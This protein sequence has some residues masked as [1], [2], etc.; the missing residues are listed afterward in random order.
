MMRLQRAKK[1][2]KTTD[3]LGAVE[4]EQRKAFGAGG[5]RRS[6]GAAPRVSDFAD[7]PAADDAERPATAGSLRSPAPSAKRSMDQ[8]KDEVAE[9]FRRG[10]IMSSNLSV[11]SKKA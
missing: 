1:K 10:D 9:K 3:H 4:A 6:I 2:A 5:R 8:I 7:A 11:A